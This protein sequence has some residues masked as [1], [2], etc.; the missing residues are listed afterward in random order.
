MTW[1][2]S[3]TVRA[4][5]ATLV[6]VALPASPRAEPAPA[7]PSGPTSLLISYRCKPADRPAFRAYLREQ[8]AARFEALKRA[9]TIADY[10]LVYSWY[11]DALSWDA[12]AIVRLER[13]ADV[14]KWNALEHESPG[15]L[16]A[17]GLALAEPD[18]T[19]SADLRW[20]DGDAAPAG[21]GR[22]LYAIPYEY[23]D[24]AEYLKFV[25]GYVI[26]QVQGWMREGILARY[27]IFLNRYPVGPTWDALFVYEY[28]DLESFGR[29]EATIAKVRG[30]LQTQ[31]EWAALHGNK[32]E[33]RSESSNV[34]ADVLAGR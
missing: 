4:L 12:M 15:G 7:P 8:G 21:S 28:A 11:H 30:P 6:L 29:R 32:H 26:P 19:V 24:R 14:A 22:V 16:D 27:R 34:I 1:R 3:L 23:R 2:P 33:L 18:V 9:G 13:Y 17:R 10:Q 25:E 20:Q 5:L 31:P